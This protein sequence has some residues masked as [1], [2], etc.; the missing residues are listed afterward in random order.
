MILQRRPWVILAITLA[1]LAGCGGGG[2][3]APFAPGVPGASSDASDARGSNASFSILIPHKKHHRGSRYVSPDTQS[4]SI[5]LTKSPGTTPM[6]T[7]AKNLTPTSPGCSVVAGI[8]T[9]CT[10]TVLLQSGEFTAL[11]S[12]YDAIDQGGNVLSQDQSVPFKVKKKQLNQFPFVLGG[13][14]H[15]LSVAGTSRY[16]RTTS[17]GVSLFGASAGAVVLT[18]KDADG[19]TIIGPDSLRYSASVVSGSGWSV[20]ATPNPSTPNTFSITPPARNGSIATLKIAFAVTAGTC[21]QSGVLCTKT[22]TAA[23]RVQYLATTHCGINCEY[24]DQ[25][26]D[27]IFVFRLPN[28]TTPFATVTSGVFEPL[29]TAF[30]PDGTLFVANCASTNCPTSHMG[31]DSV[32]VYA[33]PYTGTPKTITNGI[34][35]PAILATNKAGDVFVDN[36]ESIFC[37]QFTGP[38]PITWYLHG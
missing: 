32:T 20:Q 37:N 5:V 11:V 25:G 16:V 17:T 21:A 6:R 4:I 13:V 29:T 18:A 35:F 36:C 8:G 10:F 38:D 33:P 19:N 3:N 15:S 27:A 7:I 22:F 31:T 23:N 26:A 9:R 14:P 24:L 2:A 28:V 12:M 1:F 34:S 30:A